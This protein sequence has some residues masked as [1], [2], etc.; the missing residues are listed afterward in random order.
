MHKVTTINLNGKAYQLEEKGYAE[1]HSYLERATKALVTNPD[2]KE[3]LADLEQAIADKCER[4]LSGTKDVISSDQID[5]ILAEMGPVQAEDDTYEADSSDETR[6]TESAKPRKLYVI[7]KGGMIA[8][9]CN[10]LAAYLG[11]DV[12]IV[13]LIF[14]L[15][16]IVSGGFWILLYVILAFVLPYANTDEQMAEA[17]GRRVTAQEIVE[18]AKG[19]AKDLEPTLN[20]VGTLIGKL[21]HIGFALLAGLLILVLAALTVGWLAILWSLAFYDLHLTAQLSQI[22]T[23]SLAA[24]S[25]AS[26][27]LIGLPLLG[28]AR[29]SLRVARQQGFSQFNKGAAWAGVIVWFG[30]LLVGIILSASTAGHV[31]DYISTHGGYLDINSHHLCVDDNRCNPNKKYDT[32]P[33]MFDRPHL[34]PIQ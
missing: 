13:R 17:Y 18:G 25:S 12:T 9:V 6:A 19:R 26:F 16:T 30:A 23:W 14:I 31:R 11:I 22:S 7:P 5:T 21:L 8:G 28:A 2:K 10:G 3:I 29:L 4:F 15:L 27:F 34:K 33:P 24:S 20:R 32:F 1:L